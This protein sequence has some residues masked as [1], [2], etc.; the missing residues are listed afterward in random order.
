MANLARA[1]ATVAQV[2]ELEVRIRELETRAG[3]REPA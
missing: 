3:L 1:I 2:G